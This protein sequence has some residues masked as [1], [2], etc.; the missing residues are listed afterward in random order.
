MD[1]NKIEQLREKLEKQKSYQ[2]RVNGKGVYSNLGNR[3]SGLASLTMSG[4]CY[5]VNPFIGILSTP[6][7]I[8]GLGDLITGQHHFVT[9]H[10]FK[11]HPKYEIAKLEKEIMLE[12]IE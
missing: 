9:Y 5:L 3:V 1:L 2:S 6:L 8:D 11:I 4:V 12:M 7:A 10:L